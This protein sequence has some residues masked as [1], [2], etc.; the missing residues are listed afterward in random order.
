MHD[1]GGLPDQ[2]GILAR[3]DGGV[4][5]C[6]ESQR[7]AQGVNAMEG[8]RIL[9]LADDEQVIL[10]PEDVKN[11]AHVPPE[12]L[13]TAGQ[14]FPFGLVEAG[15]WLTASAPRSWPKLHERDKPNHGDA[16]RFRLL[17][18]RGLG[19]PLAG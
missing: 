11:R 2:R 15:L 10:I 19:Q 14:V 9:R 3:F 13:D 16:P 5:P 6:D 7:L 1:L 8:S 12:L 17:P 4:R 18:P